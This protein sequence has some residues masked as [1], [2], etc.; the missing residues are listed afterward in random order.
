MFCEDHV[1]GQFLCFHV[2]YLCCTKRSS[3]IQIGYR[4]EDP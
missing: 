3:R 1:G 2:T 4:K